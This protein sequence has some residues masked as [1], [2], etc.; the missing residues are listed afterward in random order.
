MQLQI[1]GEDMDKNLP[2]TFLAHQRRGDWTEPPLLG[3]HV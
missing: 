2:L 3:L 1:F